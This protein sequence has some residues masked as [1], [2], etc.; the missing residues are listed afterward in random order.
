MFIF[1]KKSCISCQT[2]FW[3]W[4]FF[5]RTNT[6]E[7]CTNT[8]KFLPKYP[9]SLQM[10]EVLKNNKSSDVPSTCADTSQFAFNHCETHG[11]DCICPTPQS[12]SWT[13]CSQVLYYQKQIFQIFAFNW[14]YVCYI[15]LIVQVKCHHA[16]FYILWI[17]SNLCARPFESPLPKD[18]SLWIMHDFDEQDVMLHLTEGAILK[19]MLGCHNVLASAQC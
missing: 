19:W 16:E 8:L 10:L 11:W 9:V 6:S 4:G 7:L 12:L 2:H 3:P 13:W 15:K 17:Q 1:F 14:F 18:I 5:F